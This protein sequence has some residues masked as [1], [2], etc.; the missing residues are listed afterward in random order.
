[1]QRNEPF[2]GE[3]GI[4]KQLVE[5]PQRRP[6]RLPDRLIPAGQPEGPQVRGTLEGV[7]RYPQEFA[8]PDR[9]IGSIAGAVPRDTQD[10][11]VQL[12]FGHT[13]Q[14]VRVVMLN[15]DQTAVSSMQCIVN[16]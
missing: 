15:R 13:G 3:Q 11:T 10:W 8:A 1:M 2:H 14:D 7:F 6:P 4:A 16:S 5:Q 9:A 12:V